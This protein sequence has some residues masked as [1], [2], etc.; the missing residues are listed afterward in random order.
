MEL[1]KVLKSMEI[2][3]EINFEFGVTYS[4]TKYGFRNPNETKRDIVPMKWIIEN[5]GSESY[6]IYK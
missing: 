4:L 2:A 1:R 6:R 3:D 5:H